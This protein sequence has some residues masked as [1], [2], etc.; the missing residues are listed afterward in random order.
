[1]W[2]YFHM[3]KKLLV[4][5]CVGILILATVG[6]SMFSGPSIKNAPVANMPDVKIVAFGDSLVQGVGATEGND[7]V[8]RVS[9]KIGRPIVN[10][11]KSGDTTRSAL[12]RL[13]LLLAENPDVVIL[14]LGGNDYLQ[15]IPKEE[16]FANLGTIV[17]RVQD[18][19]GAVLLL[20]VRGGA[21]RDTYE[22]DFADFARANQTGYVS[23]V[24]DGLL[25]DRDLM[26]D[27]IHPNDAGYEIIAER[28][29]K[30]LL[31]EILK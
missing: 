6:F 7:F 17:S 11:G 21:I 18:S 20:G 29:A 12:T 16:T 19:G 2:Y 22:T 3:S 9:A 24:L 25:N 4:I 26:S 28:V 31:N 10:L 8:S 1:M 14:L 30:E 5:L 13:D 15:R 23:N 27:A